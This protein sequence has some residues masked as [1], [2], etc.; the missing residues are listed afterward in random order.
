M[1]GE[2]I[3]VFALFGVFVLF[4]LLLSFGLGKYSPKELGDIGE[5]HVRKAL[6]RSLKKNKGIGYLLNDV[7]IPHAQ[8]DHIVLL[9]YGIFVIETKYW[10]GWIFAS[11]R[12]RFWTQCQWKHRYRCESPIFQNEAHIRRLSQFLH[13]SPLYFRSVIVMDGGG[14]M[15]TPEAMPVYVVYSGKQAAQYIRGFEGEKRRFSDEELTQIYE[16]LAEKC[17]GKTWYD[18]KRYDKA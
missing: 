2:V 8:I 14:T 9:P 16:T 3:F 15:K 1:L 13:V 12:Q 18:K 10:S 4:V 6:V 5:R 11:E 17:C 7:Q